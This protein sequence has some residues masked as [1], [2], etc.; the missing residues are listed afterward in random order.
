MFTAA[1]VVSLV[2][3]WFAPGPWLEGSLLPFVAFGLIFPLVVRRQMRTRVDDAPLAPSGASIQPRE[4]TVRNTALLNLP[5][6]L[7]FGLIAWEAR[8]TAVVI[9]LMLAVAF[10]WYSRVIA[11]WE[12]ENRAVLLMRWRWWFG[13]PRYYRG[14]PGTDR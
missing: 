3:A 14:T 7:L 8:G 4:R 13:P 6:F 2:V 11:R 12:E 1:A 9:S 10:R 5:V